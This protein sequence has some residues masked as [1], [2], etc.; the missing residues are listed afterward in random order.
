MSRLRVAFYGDDF[1]GASDNAAQYSRHGLRSILF[2]SDPGEARLREAALDHDVI[3]IA[4]TARSTA[5]ARMRIELAPVFASLK[6]LNAPLMQYKCC[7]TFD[8]SPGTGSLGEAARLMR[9]TWP[10]GFVPVL[11]AMPEFGRY[12]I[13]GTHYAADNGVV[14]R[15]DR[16]P[17]MSRHPVTPMLEADLR[18]VLVTQG[19]EV[20]RLVDYR[21]LEREAARVPAFADAF[22]SGIRAALF[23]AADDRQLTTAAAT[24]WAVAQRHHVT[25]IASQGLGH[26][27]GLHLRSTGLIEGAPPTHRLEATDRLLVFS[28]SCSPQSAAQIAWAE[29]HGFRGIRIAG[30]DL[31]EQGDA[32]DRIE[33]DVVAALGRGTSVVVYT[34]SGPDDPSIAETNALFATEGVSLAERVGSVCARLLRVA[35]TRAGVR[36]L[37]VAGGD[38]S[39]FAMRHLGADGFTMEASHFGQNAHV[40]VLSSTDRQVDGIEILLKGGQVGSA[41]LYGI[42]LDGF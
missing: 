26:G 10:G 34:A 24:I 3:G 13:F 27:L 41:E 17:T 29:Q 19:F 20:D 32:L 42:M 4:G 9:E 6:A 31:A 16:H 7:S 23:D 15:L 8:S 35:I 40:G 2:F 14:H 1:T 18:R 39:S 37:V 28:G 36:R 11:A 38:S 21:E 22:A 12:T 33:R 5:T 30:R 25:A